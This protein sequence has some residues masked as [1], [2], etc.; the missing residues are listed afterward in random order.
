MKKRVTYFII[1]RQTSLVRDFD[2][3]SLLMR[4]IREP[5]SFTNQFQ[6]WEL[7]DYAMEYLKRLAEVKKLS[8][9]A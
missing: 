6:K 9:S 4:A 2:I 1:K 7:F 8:K 5:E 3:R